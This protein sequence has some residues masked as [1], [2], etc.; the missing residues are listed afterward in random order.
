MRRRKIITISVVVI[1]AFSLIVNIG[2]LKSSQQLN[3]ESLKWAVKSQF[4]KYE[5]IKN[6]K[7]KPI[8]HKNGGMDYSEFLGKNQIQNQKELIR[9]IGPTF[10]IFGLAEGAGFAGLPKGLPK[11]IAKTFPP[12]TRNKNYSSFRTNKRIFTFCIN[13][14]CRTR[15]NNSCCFK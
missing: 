11:T 3:L 6:G 13:F 8:T 15:I 2:F 9:T 7:I 10:S 14:Y 5:E 12:M 4:I 1:L